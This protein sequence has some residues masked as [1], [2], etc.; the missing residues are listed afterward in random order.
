MMKLNI[1][2]D[3]KAGHFIDWTKIRSANLKETN[4]RH[5]VGYLCFEAT[6]K[7]LLDFEQ[8]GDNQIVK[9]MKRN[10]YI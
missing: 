6:H 2:I 5:Y 4:L 10:K 9:Y 3:Q 1:I 8:V 7:T